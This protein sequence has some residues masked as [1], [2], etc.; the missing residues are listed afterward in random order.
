MDPINLDVVYND[1]QTKTVS[2]IAIDLMRFEQHF[3]MS[4]AGL[5]TPKLTHLF[6]LAYSVEKRTKATDLEFDAWVE[7]I[8][9]VREGSTKK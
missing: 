2:A 8:Q 1:G 5:S 7:S 4:I 6:Y 3:D 9:A